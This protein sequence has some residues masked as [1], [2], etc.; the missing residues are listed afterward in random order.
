M[1]TRELGIKKAKTLPQ[2]ILEEMNDFIDFLRTQKERKNDIWGW[3]A[4]NQE[5]I[6]ESDFKDYSKGLNVLFILKFYYLL[7]AS[8]IY[9][10]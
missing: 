9:A 4:R 8:L 1:S 3:L 2:N 5:K 7:F 6:G 10:L